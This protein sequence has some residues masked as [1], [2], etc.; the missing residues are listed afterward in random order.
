MFL[1]ASNT[2]LFSH[3]HSKFSARLKSNTTSDV[4]RL[5][6]SCHDGHQP[7][8]FEQL[9][10]QFSIAVGEKKFT[11]F[12]SKVKTLLL[13]KNLTYENYVSVAL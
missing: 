7:V 5:F 8:N 13:S 3:N 4:T 11:V 1:G 2:C 6:W 9:K 10:K 12:Q